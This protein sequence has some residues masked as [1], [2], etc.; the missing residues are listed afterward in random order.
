MKEAKMEDEQS[1][2]CHEEPR[3]SVASLIS[4]IQPQN[5]NVN[6]SVSYMGDNE[7]YS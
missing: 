3:S 1:V 5:S 7:N 4:M 6:D 2:G